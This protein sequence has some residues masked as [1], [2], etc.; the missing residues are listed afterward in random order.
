[1]K[2]TQGFTLFELLVTV[3]ILGIV[4]AIAMPSLSEFVVKMRVDGE[5]SQLQRMLLTA[6]NGAISNEQS[7]TVCP[8]NASNVC[9]NDWK[10]E[11]TVFTDIDNDGIFEAANNEERIKVKE[12]NTTNDTLTFSYARVTY[13]PDGFLGGIYNATFKYCPE[14]FSDLSRGI[15]ISKVSG[16]IYTSFDSNNDGKEENRSGDVITC[17]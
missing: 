2:R 7:V 10:G 15:I 9:Q 1:M 8:L 5:I 3:A 12:A 17:I 14:S 11:I 4:T 16:R 6:R 13:A